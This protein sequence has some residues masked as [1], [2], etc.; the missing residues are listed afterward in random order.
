MAKVVLKVKNFFFFFGATFLAI[1]V[2]MPLG[3]TCIWNR[4]PEY[5]DKFVAFFLSFNIS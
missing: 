3:S 4:G 2:C 1:V 5:L